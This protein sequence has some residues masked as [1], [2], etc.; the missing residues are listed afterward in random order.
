MTNR[1]PRRPW[2]PDDMSAAIEL[3]QAGANDQTLERMLRRSASAV[4]RYFK[5]RGVRIAQV[6]RVDGGC[7]TMVEM[8]RLMGVHHSHVP[9]WIAA[10]ELARAGRGRY[11]GRTSCYI[12]D[13]ALLDFIAHRPAW[14]DWSPANIADP[15]WREAAEDLRRAAGG[16]WMTTDDI[17]ARYTVVQST[18][19]GWIRT[20]RLAAMHR[21]RCYYIWSATLDGWEPPFVAYD[22]AAMSASSRRG[23]ETRRRRAEEL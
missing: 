13:P 18:V 1:F 2:T 16:Y 14:P 7:R 5:V 22:Q 19:E 9:G 8:A 20:G 11:P 21:K 23:H 3:L 12:T 17:A 10:G 15:D 6:R 4:R